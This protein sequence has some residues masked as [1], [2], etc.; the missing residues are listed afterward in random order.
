MKYSIQIEC[1]S[2]YLFIQVQI[3]PSFDPSTDPALEHNTS[4]VNHQITSVE[5]APCL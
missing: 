2:V 3:L 5:I 4:A 1:T